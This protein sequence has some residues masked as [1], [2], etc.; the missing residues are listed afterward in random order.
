MTRRVRVVITTAFAALAI[1][2]PASAGTFDVASCADAL[3]VNHAWDRTVSDDLVLLAT[4][5]C[6]AAD[7]RGGLTVRERMGSGPGA[8]EGDYAAWSITAPEQALIT[9]VRYS[10][11]LRAFS[12]EGWRP[13]LVTEDGTTL[14]HCTFASPATQCSV[15]TPTPLVSGHDVWTRSVSLR[16]RCVPVYF[17]VCDRGGTIQ[18]LE[19]VLYGATVTIDDLEAPSVDAPSSPAA[20]GRWHNEATAAVTVAAADNTGIRMRRVFVGDEP[21]ADHVAPGPEAGG[22]GELNVGVAYTY[23]KP[24]DQDRG[25]NGARTT[26]FP[27]ARDG[28][29]AVTVEVTDTGGRTARSH[30]VTVRVDGTPPP[31]VALDGAG[32]WTAASDASVSWVVPAPGVGSPVTR[33]EVEVCKPGSACTS[34]AVASPSPGQRLAQDVADL[35]E[36]ETTVR[37]RHVDEAGNVGDWST[38]A[39]RVDRTA[40]SVVLSAPADIRPGSWMYA[41]AAGVDSGAGVARTEIEVSVDG[42]PWQPAGDAVAAFA[43]RTYRFRARAADHA[44]NVGV[45]HVGDPIRVPGGSFDVPAPPTPTPVPT[46]APSPPAK[47]TATTPPPNPP[48]VTRRAPALALR[49]VKVRGSVLLITGTRV[50][51]A[52][53]P[54]V[55]TAT[56]RERGR[57]R[58]LT[59]TV[60]VS[61]GR[62]SARLR[63]PRAVRGRTRVTVRYGGDRVWLPA[64]RSRRVAIPGR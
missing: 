12:D 54:V 39:I 30:P 40:P 33:A 64:V 22:C 29:H 49:T 45:W 18:S 5:S 46:P 43:G 6:G 23:T 50:A 14:E 57:S 52:T 2:T 58:T 56:V 42:G 35:P 17:G 44:G 53:G 27:L 28:V 34:R 7:G 8:G 16:G 37:V 24:C 13:E 25:L 10:T 38:A 15:G 4:D 11:Y 1:S 20:D 55:V 61:A 51:T 48:A 59:R 19:A 60:S 32:A 26:T 62:F 63:L 41:T 3:G 21:V 36:G 31:P 9:R 47:P